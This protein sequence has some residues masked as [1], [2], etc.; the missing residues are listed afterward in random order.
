MNL[1]Q[2]NECLAETED[3]L[4]GGLAATDVFSKQ[5]GMSIAGIRTAPKACALFNVVCERTIDSVK[6]SGLP[7]PQELS[8]LIITLGEDENVLI[9]VIDIEWAGS[10]EQTIVMPW[11]LIDG[12]AAAEAFAAPFNVVFGGVDEKKSGNPNVPPMKLTFNGA[13]ATFTKLTLTGVDE[14]KTYRVYHTATVL[15]DGRVLLVGGLDDQ[16]RPTASALVFIGDK[17]SREVMLNVARF[18]H[19]VSTLRTGLIP[20][21]LLIVGGFNTDGGALGA[22]GAAELFVTQ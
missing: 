20:N 2:V 7:I 22:I 15:K 12:Q 3:Q 6:K 10:H 14:K 4:M 19:S 5:S 18:G 21:A 9:A 13:T 16:R 11:T 17:Y 1:K 8:S